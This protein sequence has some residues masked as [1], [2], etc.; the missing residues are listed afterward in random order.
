MREV[1]PQYDK[2]VSDTAFDQMF[3]RDMNVLCESDIPLRIDFF[4]PFATMNTNY[5]Y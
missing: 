2:A 5:Y 4:D 3:E 1:V